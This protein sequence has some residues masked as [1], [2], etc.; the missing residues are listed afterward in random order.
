MKI[1][2]Y[3]GR[4]FDCPVTITR[5]IDG[6]QA[7]RVGN[8]VLSRKNK[9]LYNIPYELLEEGKAYEV[10]TGD[11]DETR[12]IVRT[13]ESARK[14]S[15]PELYELSPDNPRLLIAKMDSVTPDEIFSFFTAQIHLGYE[16][17]IIYEHT[18]DGDV[19]WKLKITETY[20]VRVTGIQAGKGKHLGRMGALLT[21]MGKVGTG[22]TDAM[23]EET[24]EIGEI[25]EVECMEIT[26]DGKFRHP[27]FIR[28]RFDK[29]T[30]NRNEQE[31]TT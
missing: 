3:D 26:E 10:F 14:I 7:K 18:D 28:R 11:F 12:S 20:D 17:L 24:W 6:V 8:Q 19:L 9:P 4:P 29:D 21:T 2:T 1:R 31:T 23:R 5:K 27:R 22:F 25:I 30:E 15:I 13:H 16:G